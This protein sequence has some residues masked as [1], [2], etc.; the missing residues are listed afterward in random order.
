MGK[1]PAVSA[2]PI[3][4]RSCDDRD[5]PLGRYKMM[6]VEMGSGS[7]AGLWGAPVDVRQSMTRCIHK[8]SLFYAHLMAS[9]ALSTYTRQQP[10]NKGV[11]HASQY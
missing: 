2:K 8:Y 10:S 7:R 1:Y 11:Q 5:E 3:F 9:P 6:T 4:N